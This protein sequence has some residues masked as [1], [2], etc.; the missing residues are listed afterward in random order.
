MTR[1]NRVLTTRNLVQIALL[2]CIA[3]LLMMVVFPLPFAPAFMEVDISDTPIMLASMTMGPLAGMVTASIKILIKLLL[4]PTSTMFIGELSNLLLSF[5]NAITVGLI[6]K[7]MHN[8]RGA[9]IAVLTTIITMSAVAVLSNA[10]VIFP[11]YAK[12]LNIDIIGLIDST[13]KINPWVLDYKGLMLYAILPFNL[14]KQALV[15]FASIVI[16]KYL[17]PLINK[18]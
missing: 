3:A 15:A 17:E 8:R 10:F 7:Y 12:Y 14:V 9:I 4:R 1:N 5:V 6:Y 2:G 16:L 11:L 18:S 13:S